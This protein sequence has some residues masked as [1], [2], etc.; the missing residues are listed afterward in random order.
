MF[1]LADYP[2]VDVA[3]MANSIQRGFGVAPIRT[4][5]VAVLRGAGWVGDA[6]KS[7][8]WRHPPLTSFRLNNLLTP[9]IHNL[10]PLKKITGELPYSM[11]EGVGITIS[12]LRS[13]GDVS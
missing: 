8:G 11:E 13:H 2:P 5:G 6:L 12:W 7:A 4:L 3:Q 1:Y 10:E 9:M